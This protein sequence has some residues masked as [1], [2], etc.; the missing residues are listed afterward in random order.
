MYFDSSLVN[1]EVYP[2]LIGSNRLSWLLLKS[3]FLMDTGEKRDSEVIDS[4]RPS[5]SRSLMKSG[6]F[7]DTEGGGVDESKKDK[8]KSE[9]VSNVTSVVD[10]LT[11]GTVEPSELRLC[12]ILNMSISQAVTQALITNHLSKDL[13]S[14]EF[15][16]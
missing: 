11:P 3:S 16:I 5:A 13:I 2:P 7:L 15:L 14:F 10:T 1:G 12:S 8:L 9:F 6:S 4:N